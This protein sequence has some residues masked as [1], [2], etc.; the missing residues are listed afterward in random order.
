MLHYSNTTDATLIDVLTM[1]GIV[2]GLANPNQIQTALINGCSTG[3][4][5]FPMINGITHSTI[6]MCSQCIDI[7]SKL[8]GNGTSMLTGESYEIGYMALPNGLFLK[9][10]LADGGYAVFNASGTSR[11]ILGPDALGTFDSILSQ[12]ED[13]SF[14]TIIPASVFN[15]TMITLSGF[16]AYDEAADNNTKYLSTACSIYSCMKHYAGLV[17][18]GNFN[19]TLEYLY[20]QSPHPCSLT[21]I[22]ILVSTLASM[23]LVSLMETP[24][25]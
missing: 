19:E 14:T 4:C 12:V 15:W 23:L 16:E 20:Q 22:S 13:H 9:T 11:I 21:T 10:I 1:G 6:G 24:M 7:T 3:N 25:T 18:R 5:T 8:Q 17:D 2:N